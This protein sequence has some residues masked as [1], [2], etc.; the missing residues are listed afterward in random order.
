[1]ESSTFRFTGSGNEYFKIWIVNILLSI[2]TLGI[3]SA[4]ASVRR[5]R[6]FYGNTWLE[7]ANFEYHA[8]PLQIL[9][10]RVIAIGLLIA[11][12]FLSNAFPIIGFGLL[13]LIMAFMP[14]LVCRSMQFNARMSSYRNVR[15]SFHG[16]VWDA[17]RYLLLIP[18]LPSLVVLL[19]AVNLYLTGI[20]DQTRFISLAGTAFGMTYLLVPYLQVLMTRYH[21]NHSQYG[22]GKFATEVSTGTFYK[23]Y[24]KWM[25]VW[26]LG[27]LLMVALFAAVALML[28]VFSGASVDKSQLSAE[29]LML[30]IL[31]L[32]FLFYA[33]LVL[34][35]MFANAY[36]KSRV[37]N[38]VF[39]QTRLDD[40]LTLD[41][42]ISAWALFK[43]Y[44]INLLMLMLTLGLATPWV[45]VRLHRYMLTN[46]PVHIKGDLGQ[47]VTQQQN[48][49]SSVG[50]E[51]GDAFDLQG[52]FEVGL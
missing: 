21:L 46:T 17:Y 42:T 34:M 22:Q 8:T 6:Y 32:I 26:S 16:G 2:V 23:I 29:T 19:F 40:V 13:L 28:G 51:M 25:V 50:D 24:V 48:L 39:K 41:S 14:W 43:V 9:L 37:R 11:Y 3:Y 4:W 12:T 44:A 35:G 10:G 27:M 36:L 45:E 47:F 33:P 30:T 7:D 31:P 38:Y 49:Q 15:F 18:L 20:H 52:G 5:R 1:M